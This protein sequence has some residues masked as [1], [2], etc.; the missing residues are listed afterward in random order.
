VRI[1]FYSPI[2]VSCSHIIVDK[3]CKN[4][5]WGLEGEIPAV[6]F[7]LSEF[8]TLNCDGDA[9]LLVHITIYSN[10]VIIA[11]GHAVA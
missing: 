2:K 9:K 8:S 4:A 3:G 6:L 5:R 1:N 11:L 10:A 7:V